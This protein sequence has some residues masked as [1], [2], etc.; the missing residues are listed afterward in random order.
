MK[1]S[2]LGVVG[3][4]GLWGVAACNSNNSP[5]GQAGSV[6]GAGGTGGAAGSNETGGTAGSNADGAAGMGGTGE[7]GMNDDGAVSGVLITHPNPIISR[8]AQVFSSPAGAAGTINDGTYH[9]GGW[10]ILAA[11]LPGWVAF[12]LTAGPTRILLSWDD[13][14]TYNYQDPTT[15][16]VY[17]LPAAYRIEVSADST[18]GSDGTWM[19]RVTVGDASTSPN[20]VRTR[21]HALDFAGMTWVKMTITAAPANESSNG[22]QLGEI[23]I[24]DISATGSGL[25]DDT[26]F[27]MGDSIT[28][29]AYDRAAAHQPSFA[30]AVNTASPTFYPAMINGGIGGELSRDGLA[31]LAHVLELNPD[32]RFFALGYGTNDAANGQLPTATFR[33]NLQSMIDMLMG[34]GRIPILA[35]IPYAGDGSHGMIPAYNTVIDELVQTNQLPI[36]PDLYTHFMQNPGEF[37]CPP[38]GGGRTTDNLHPNDVGLAA[39][40]TLWA[41]AARPLYP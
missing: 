20:Q 14:G 5:G 8:T 9:N 41:T 26:W 6:G 11:S 37:T 32:F 17:G 18:N 24:H 28:A 29:F 7:A 12:K 40:N 3:F 35:R 16:T 19:P 38:C 10:R 34:A 22:V 30:R 25:P 21:A 13:G 33:T 36:G 15:V 4:L 39:M 23:D 27:F 2:L 1:P 31:R